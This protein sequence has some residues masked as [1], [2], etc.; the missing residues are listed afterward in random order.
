MAGAPEPPLEELLWTIAAARLVLP[1]EVHVQAPPNLT[2]DEFPRLL[3]A[4]IDDWGGVSPV[5]IDHVNPEAPWPEVERLRA[6]TEE[7]RARARAA[8]PVY[9]ELRRPRRALVRPATSPRAVRRTSDAG[10]LARE[11]GWAAGVE[12]P[13][14]RCRTASARSRVRPSGTPLADASRA[15]ASSTRTDATALLAARGPDL[16]RVLAAADALRREVER[17]RRHLRRHAER[18][19]HERLLLPLRLL[20]LLEGQARRE[21]ARRAVPRPARSE[22][23]RR[24]REAWERGATEI[25]LQG[26][27]HPAFT[28]D[29]YLEICRAVKEAVPGHPRARVLARSRSGRARRRSAC[30]CDDYLVRLRDAGL[31]SLPG[32]GRRDP[33]RRGA[34]GDLPGQGHDRRSGSRCTRPR[35][36]VGLRSND[37]DH[38]RPRRAARALGAPPARACATCSGGRAASPSSCRCRSCT[39]RRRSTSRAARARGRRSARR[40]SCT[41]SA[42]LALHPWID[43]RPGLVGEARP[44]RR[45]APRCAAGVQRPRRHA[46]ER[47]DLARRRRRARPGAAARADGGG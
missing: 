18:Q 11:D 24:A 33:R 42:R 26:G 36:R 12:T 23:A 40:C 41:R 34:R 2:Y 22:I 44:G 3:D 28:G 4:G 10:G 25:C 9:P 16:R 32:H 14:P 13:F 38:V 8:A 31:A 7:P 35:T 46:D 37:D 1:P 47:V 39:W 6:A 45:R 19:L 17:R 5:T 43:E 30:R 29:S 20:R 15:A 27:I 21:P